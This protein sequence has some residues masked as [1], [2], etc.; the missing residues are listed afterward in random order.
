MKKYFGMLVVS[1][2]MFASV[3]MANA[4]DSVLTWTN[5][6]TTYGIQIEK[7]SSINGTYVMI[8]Q[9]AP[10]V[11]MFTDSSNVAGDTSCYRIAYFNTSGVGPYTGAVCKTFPLVPTQTPAGLG[12]N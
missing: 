8:N 2:M 3:G 12:V 4:L 1:I 6:A 11:S 10:N 5:T 9:T 7:S